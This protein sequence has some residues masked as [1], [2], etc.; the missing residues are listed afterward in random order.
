MELVVF[1]TKKNDNRKTE[2]RT[3][4]AFQ[5]KSI[6]ISRIWVVSTLRLVNWVKGY[7]WLCLPIYSKCKLPS[8]EL[9]KTRGKGLL[10]GS[11]GICNF[12]LPANRLIQVAAFLLKSS[13]LDLAASLYL[14]TLR[15]STANQWCSLM[16]PLRRTTPAG[17]KKCC[18]VTN[19]TPLFTFDSSRSITS[20]SGR[21]CPNWR[22]KE[23]QLLSFLYNTAVKSTGTVLK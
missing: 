23:L 10:W 4:K 14:W 22:W 13:F 8:G 21:L 12:E 15:S 2:V 16:P 6:C 11:W 1:G 20:M 3:H 9:R 7:F 19:L 18:P 5:L 17:E